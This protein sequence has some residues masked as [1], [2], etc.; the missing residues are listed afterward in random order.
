[1]VSFY[2]T[3]TVR[4]SRYVPLLLR[5]RDPQFGSRA[6]ACFFSAVGGWPWPAARHPPSRSLAPPPPQDRKWDGKARGW[7]QGDHLPISVVGKTGKLIYCLLKRSWMGRNPYHPLFLGSA[8]GQHLLWL[9]ELPVLP[10]RL[11]GSHNYCILFFFYL[12]H[13]A[14]S[15]TRFP[16]MTQ[17]C[18]GALLCPVVRRLEPAGTGCVRHEAALLLLTEPLLPTPGHPRPAQLSSRSKGS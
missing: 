4:K 9:P 10:Q 13:F 8:S 18:W 7:R 17:H 12:T 16:V 6:L 11:Q 14:R 15:H 1:M 3:G 2:W 5:M